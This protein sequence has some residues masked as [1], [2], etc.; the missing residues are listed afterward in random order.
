MKQYV[1]YFRLIVLLLT[2]PIQCNKVALCE[3]FLTLCLIRGTTDRGHLI[4]HYLQY[5]AALTNSIIEEETDF[6]GETISGDSFAECIYFNEGTD[7]TTDGSAAYDT[8]DVAVLLKKLEHYGI[9]GHE[10]QL[11]QSYLTFR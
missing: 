10:Q 7:C 4:C 11:I 8:V 9:C 1:T 5:A 3:S 2:I 6:P